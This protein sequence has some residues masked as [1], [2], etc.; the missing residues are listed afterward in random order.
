MLSEKSGMH[1]HTAGWKTYLT[2]YRLSFLCAI[3]AL[4]FYAVGFGSALAFG[5]A[6]GEAGKLLIEN[7][8]VDKN[9]YFEAVDGFV[10]LNL[11]KGIIATVSR[12]DHGD[13]NSGP[14]RS[15]FRN[16]EL[17]INKEPYTGLTEPT[18]LP[19]IYQYY[20]IAPIFQKWEACE[21]YYQI[22]GNCLEQN[23]I[24]GWALAEGKS[25]CND[26]N[27]VACK[28]AVPELRPVYKCSSA[29]K[30]YGREAM[31][32]VEGL[33][34]RVLPPPAVPEEVFDELSALFVVDGWPGSAL[35]SPS[36]VWINV[37]EDACIDN[38]GGCMQIWDTCKLIA[39]I[40]TVVT[41][42]CI[43]IPCCIDYQMD[44]RI[45]EVKKYWDEK[46]AASKIMA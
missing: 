22:S 44:K 36:Q 42:L 35:P 11:T 10:A 2:C 3:P 6:D 18:R 34:G 13:A 29:D 31:G 19:G 28:T 41:V 17:L 20:V 15:R 23:P 37:D 16:A 43:A 33:C 8:S 25:L 45:R 9:N 21:T 14:R 7:V 12:T 4:I 26:I 40:F 27:L 46:Q 5:Q 30:M 39:I 1:P 32:A 38:P 24:V